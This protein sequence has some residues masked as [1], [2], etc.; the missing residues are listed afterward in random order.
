M[1]A[2]ILNSGV[3]SR[4]ADITKDKPKCMIKLC[5]EE[6]IFERQI[7]ILSEC[8]IKRF[9]VT[10]GPFREQ[11]YETA[12]RFPD[13]QFQFVHNWDYRTTN[14]IVSLNYAAQ[15]LNDDVLLLHGDLVFNRALVQKMINYSRESL[16]LYNDTIEL[17]KKDFKGR[18]KNGMLK[19]VSVEI[20][21]RDCFA[22]QPMYKLC[23]NDMQQWLK[24]ISEYTADGKVGV[25]AE[26]ALNDI[27]NQ[28]HIYGMS[29]KDDYINEIDNMNDYKKVSGEIVNFDFK[30]QKIIFT[31]DYLSVLG[32]YIRKDEDVFLVCGKNVLRIVE[33]EL[34]V[35]NCR[36]TVF[37]DF[38]PNPNF[39]D[40]KK[41][42]ELLKKSQCKKIVSIG[43][44][45]TVDTAKTIN[46]LYA[47]KSEED[48]FAGRLCR[49]CLFHIA[50]PTTAGSGS[51]STQF[52]AVYVNNK[53]LSIEHSLIIP[54]MA[55]YDYH[56]LKYL[57]DYQKKSAMA[58][59]LC[60]AIESYWA[61]GATK[62][63]KLYSIECIELI[64]EY[65]KA[66]LEEDAAAAR[67][68]MKASS[69]SGKAINISKTTAPHAMSYMLT[70][71][72][73]ISHGHSAAICLVPCWRL[74]YE[75]SF[76]DEELRKILYELAAEL[77]QKN[78]PESIDFIGEIISDFNFPR[79]NIKKDDLEIL[80]SSVNEK[81]MSNNPVCFKKEEI[82]K[83]YAELD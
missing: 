41:G 71:I 59:A 52:A 33:K 12:D 17:P 74:L 42:A 70:S 18:F 78:I 24:K 37:S 1:E 75:K 3:G 16:C 8:G 39:D 80:S 28:I 81:R 21:D 23:K 40:I 53:K 6:T 69:L 72:Y 46:L 10:T 62:L 82:Y 56:F 57:P 50:I 68:I 77:K 22:F 64:A 11:L 58:D 65:Y 2:V 35:L 4:M 14:Y 15:Y 27:L 60:Q 20:F 43:G 55:V 47:A 63:S 19:E 30:E 32:K 36:F 38:T 67:K 79:V 13:L 76:C 49:Q 9:V 51:E 66:Y 26:A 44:G 61:K 54:N 29:Y 83:I 73:G 48:V 45:S 34:C 31:D 5:G 7:R 25:Y